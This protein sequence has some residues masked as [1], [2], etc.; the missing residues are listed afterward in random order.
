MKFSVP[1]ITLSIAAMANAHGYFVSPPPRQP[2]AVFT[3]A[4][5]E[6]AYNMFSSDING[7]S[8]GLLQVVASQSDYNPKKCHP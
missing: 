4:C 1:A 3:K 7:N 5:G 2:G 8:Q 6:Q